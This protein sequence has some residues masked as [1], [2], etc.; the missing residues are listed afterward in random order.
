MFDGPIPG[1]SR[2][3]RVLPGFGMVLGSAT[4]DGTVAVCTRVYCDIS[5]FSWFAIGS[6]QV[7]RT[8]TKF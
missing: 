4:V 2:F 6:Q 5:G 1:L 3:Y 8:N 7:L